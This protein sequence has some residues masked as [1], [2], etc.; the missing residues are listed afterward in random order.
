MAPRDLAG[1]RVLVVDDNETNREVLRR[2]LE[3]RGVQ[4]ETVHGAEAALEALASAGGERGARYDAAV[5][6]LG[7]ALPDRSPQPRHPGRP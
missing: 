7:C 6:D 5:V 3:Q 1:L 2:Q 4:V